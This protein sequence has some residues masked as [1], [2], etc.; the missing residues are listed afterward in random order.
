MKFIETL[1]ITE[2]IENIDL[3]NERMNKTRYDFFKLPPIDLKDFIVKIEDLN[4]SARSFNC[5]DRSNIKLIGEIALMSTNDLK[6]VKNL[7]KKSLEEIKEVMKKEGYPVDKELP[8]EIVKV[9]TEKINELKSK[10][11][12]E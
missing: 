11:S 1:L 5:L 10:S 8:P 3:H 6:N 4:L 7:G 2:K 9:L 12:K